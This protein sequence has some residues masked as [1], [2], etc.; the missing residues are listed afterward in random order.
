MNK[1]NNFIFLGSY[2]GEGVCGSHRQERII[3]RFLSNDIS[4][5]LIKASGA[6]SGIHYFSADTNDFST[7]LEKMKSTTLKDAVRSATIL[8]KILRKL[9]RLFLGELILSGFFTSLYLIN[10]T[11]RDNPEYNYTLI[12]SSPPM[13]MALAAYITSKLSKTDYIVDMRDAWAL[14]TNIKENKLLRKKIEGK[15]LS[16]AKSVITVSKYLANEFET[17]HK[18]NAYVLYN[19]ATQIE[20]NNIK[21]NIN[22]KNNLIDLVYFGSLPEGFYDLKSFCTGVSMYK[23][24]LT[25][26]GQKEIIKFRFIGEHY[27]LKKELQFHPEIQ[28]MFELIPP[29]SHREA[30]IAMQYCSAVLF[31]GYDATL[32][33]GVVSTKIFEYLGLGI[34]ILPFGIRKNSDLDF[35]FET[36]CKKSFHITSAIEL[37]D[38]LYKAQFNK[39]ILLKTTNWTYLAEITS[40]YDKYILENIK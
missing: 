25:D 12:A 36:S 11:L 32:N 18:I 15:I 4:I 39:N 8:N 33:A 26:K 6:N 30:I 9:K 7:W 24:K 34:H 2:V 5:T 14:H 38:L 17:S 29:I 20:K 40:S 35:I 13:S 16:G 19:I 31:L 21:N 23:K 3:R 10:K 1:N 37:S 27:E 28:D 22:K